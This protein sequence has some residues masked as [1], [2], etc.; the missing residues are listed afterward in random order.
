MALTVSPARV[1]VSTLKIFIL[2]F[3]SLSF[4]ER[5]SKCLDI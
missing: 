1:D 3:K 4:E 5:A 2:A